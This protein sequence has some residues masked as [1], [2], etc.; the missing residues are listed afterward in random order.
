MK[1]LYYLGGF[2]EKYENVAPEFGDYPPAGQ[3]FKWLFLHFDPHMF[4]EGLAF[5]GY[6]IMNISFLLPLLRRIKGRNVPVI[7]LAAAALWFLPS[8]A[9][10]YGYGGFMRVQGG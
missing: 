9:E 3:L 4:R 8:I 7:L 1:S 2:A 6:Y 10:V 5:V